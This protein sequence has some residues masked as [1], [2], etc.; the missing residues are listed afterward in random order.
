MYLGL[1]TFQS[2]PW[3]L[4]NGAPPLRYGTTI[5][6]IIKKIDEE[7]GGGGGN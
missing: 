5:L 7:N 4:Y 6:L 3:I 2:P 1:V